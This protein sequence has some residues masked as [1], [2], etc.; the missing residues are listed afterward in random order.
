M[1]TE[2]LFKLGKPPAY[3]CVMD[4][5]S[6]DTVRMTT[7]LN[8]S[9]SVV[10]MIRGKKSTTVREFFDEISAALQFPYYFGENWAAFEECIVDLDWVEGE[11][12]L[13]LINN[14]SLL[15]SQDDLEDFKILM[16]IFSTA[17][18]EWL[19]PNQYNPRDRQ[20]TPFHVLFQCNES[21]VASFMEK[22]T[23]VGIDYEQLDLQV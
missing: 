1:D 12:Y 11:A 23:K 8:F 22:L 10:R 7:A 16:R 2:K 13:L 5:R 9:Q 21:D 14:A 18:E 20:P 3:V 6:F 15:L 4:E 17:N 19:T